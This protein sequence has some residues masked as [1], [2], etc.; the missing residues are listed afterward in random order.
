MRVVSQPP[1]LVPISHRRWN[2]VRHIGSVGT[3]NRILKTAACDATLAFTETQVVKRGSLFA[4][5]TS[6]FSVK[7]KRGIENDARSAAHLPAASCSGRR[8]RRRRHDPGAPERRN[9][10]DRIWW[11]RRACAPTTRKKVPERQR[12]SAALTL[13]GDNRKRKPIFCA[14]VSKR[15]AYRP[16]GH[17][18]AAG[19][20]PPRASAHARRRTAIGARTGVSIIVSSKPTSAV[21]HVNNGWPAPGRREREWRAR[22]PV[23]DGAPFDYRE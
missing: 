1:T 5:A 23:D 8:A 16:P 10:P 4:A 20:S 22:N 21:K 15:E 12:N 19:F 6:T 11:G 17:P 18:C 7:V 14:S 13:V 2:S 3:A 9:I